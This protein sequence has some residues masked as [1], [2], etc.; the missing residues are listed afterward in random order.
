MIMSVIYAVAIRNLR[1]GCLVSSDSGRIRVDDES[2]GL[3]P[4]LYENQTLTEAGMGSGLRIV[5]EPG[6]APLDSQVHK[7]LLI[8]HGTVAECISY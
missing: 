5:I 1:Y 7:R 8:I 2:G 4:P 6:K 3:G